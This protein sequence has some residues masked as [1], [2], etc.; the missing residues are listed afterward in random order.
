MPA[1]PIFLPG[2]R[3]GVQQGEQIRGYGYTHDGAVASI[4]DFLFASNFG[5][6]EV[7]TPIPPLVGGPVNNPEGIK[8]DENGNHE[9]EALE[10][11]IFAM[12]SNFAPIVG[13]QVTLTAYNSAAANARINLFLARA[14][15]D[16][17]ELIAFNSDTREGYLFSGG[18]FLRDKAN[19]PPLTD[20]QLRG[21]A[22]L[23]ANITFMCVP[24]GNGRRLAL[25]RDLN[26]V[27]NGD[28]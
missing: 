6:G 10:A 19:K 5:T 18:V 8:L 17:C 1:S 7:Q 20:S 16:E 21:L 12:D 9:R 11:F 2:P 23:E 28:Q 14:S 27:L 22:R 25:D 4:F 24:K 13:Q 26:G 15:A 3:F